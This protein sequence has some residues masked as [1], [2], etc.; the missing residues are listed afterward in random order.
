MILQIKI[1]LEA[2]VTIKTNHHA[3]YDML[4]K[5]FRSKRAKFID[6]CHKYLQHQIRVGGLVC[7]ACTGGKKWA[8]RF[9]EPLKRVMCRAHCCMESV[10]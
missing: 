8:D 1:T 3:A 6:S 9:T 4:H 7:V 5:P 10:D 2:A